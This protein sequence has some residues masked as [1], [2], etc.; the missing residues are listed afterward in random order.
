[1][2]NTYAIVFP[3]PIESVSEGIMLLKIGDCIIFITQGRT[4]VT[5]M[6]GMLFSIVVTYP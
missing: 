3:R 2:E 5:I 4:V 6:V 1:M